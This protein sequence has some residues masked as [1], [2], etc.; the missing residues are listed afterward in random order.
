LTSLRPETVAGIQI[1]RQALALAEAGGDAREITSKGGRDIVTATDVAVE[2]LIR[3][4]LEALWPYPVVGEERGG[5]IPSDGS[6][7]WLVDP[8]CGTRNFASGNSLYCVNLALIEGGVVTVAVVGDPS[9]REVLYA[10]RG[11]GAWAVNAAGVIR[12]SVSNDSQTL[13][14]EDGKAGQDRRAHAAQFVAEAIRSDRWEFRSLGTTLALPY[15]AAG[16]ISAY[17]V[18]Y[19]TAVHV[20]AGSLLVAEAGGVL[21]DL[22]GRPWT[23][24][25]TSLL[26]SATADLQAG[27]LRM[28]ASTRP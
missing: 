19:V 16:R 6:P 15:L 11:G 28:V 25:S 17:A 7:Y 24:K 1:V 12:V 20:A 9:R 22:E 14:V 18:F 23:L 2:D 13:V 26:F 3:A 10:E 8:I 4:G 27:L 21:C 5:V